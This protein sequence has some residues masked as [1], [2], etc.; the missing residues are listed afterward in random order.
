MSKPRFIAR[1][2]ARPIDKE[3][4]SIDVSV[5]NVQSSTIVRT[6]AV[7]ETFNGGMLSGSFATVNPV[8]NGRC[9]A[10]LV[11]V[12]FGNVLKTIDLGNAAHT[13]HPHKEV[14]WGRV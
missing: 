13:Y 14:L 10:L 9:I 3:I 5:N 2:T 4:R 6:A 11:V 12:R 8:A 7:A 1:K